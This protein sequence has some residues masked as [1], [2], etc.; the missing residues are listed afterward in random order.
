M[1][2]TAYIVMWVALDK[3]SSYTCLK[4]LIFLVRNL[5][6]TCCNDAVYTS[7]N[8]SSL[9][10]SPPLFL[11]SQR[12]IKHFVP[13]SMSKSKSIVSSCFIVM[14]N[15]H[16]FHRLFIFFLKSARKKLSQTFHRTQV[17]N[18]RK[19]SVSHL[20]ESDIISLTSLSSG[21]LNTSARIFRELIVT[22]KNWSQIDS[23]KTVFSF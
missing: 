1:I 23:H 6:F 11:Y 21:S 18:K 5:Y 20:C 19:Y 2:Y 8:S 3:L 9:H 13:P 12:F 22:A 4:I 14:P 7:I 10:I 17:E 16:S 15:F